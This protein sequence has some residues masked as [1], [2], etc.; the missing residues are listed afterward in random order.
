MKVIPIAKATAQSICGSLTQTSKMPCKSL[1]LPTESCITGFRM[2]KIAGSICATCYADKGFY[3]MYQNTI[4]PAQF[5]RLDAVWQAMSNSADAELWVSGLVSLIGKDEYFRWH[6]S[7][8]LQGVDHLRL[9][10]QVCESTPNCTH[11]LPTREYAIVKDY[12]AKFGALPDNLIVRLSA[13]YPDKPV[14]IPASLQG[15]KNVT[16]SNVHTKPE[17]ATGFV[18]NAPANN[19]ACGDCRACWSD[20]TVT[21][22]LH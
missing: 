3:S 17:N 11:W 1:S 16:A 6:D 2:S 9:I 5:A 22:A 14:T 7:G 21:Y 10:A 4:K 8:D 19:G 20:A 15:I 12:L 13:M 18:C